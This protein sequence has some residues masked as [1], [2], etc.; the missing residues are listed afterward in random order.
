MSQTNF[1]SLNK[2][3]YHSIFKKIFYKKSFKKNQIVF[4]RKPP[5]HHLHPQKDVPKSLLPYT[6]TPKTIPI[7]KTSK[8]IS[9]K[10]PHYLPI[11][12]PTKLSS[13]P[14]HHPKKTPQVL[15]RLSKPPIPPIP[16]ASISHKSC[17]ASITNQSLRRKKNVGYFS[18]LKKKK[19]FLLKNSSINKIVW[20]NPTHPTQTNA[21]V[22]FERITI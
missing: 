7:S 10:F 6:N 17:L 2:Y 3:F 1:I 5:D 19:L 4:P 18:N 8:L 11:P 22:R 13:S 16:S 15:L 21:P 20:F 9:F 14:H 12:H